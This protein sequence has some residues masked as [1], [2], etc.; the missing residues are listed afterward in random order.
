MSGHV[1]IREL[2]EIADGAPMPLHA[3]RCAECL[4]R[5]SFLRAERE[6]LRRTAARDERSV[7]PLWSGVQAR[8]ARQ[9]RSHRVVTAAL[10]AA[11][12]GGVI[13]LVARPI[14]RSPPT[15]AGPRAALDRAESEYLQ[16]ID[17]LESRIEVRERELP[18]AAL[19]ERRAARTRTRSAIAQARARELPGRMRQLEGYAAYLRSL[20][21]EL[22]E[23]P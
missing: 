7:E 11:A 12:L 1:S 3:A 21:R 17:V 18:P 14:H 22:E 20:R 4:R 2:E 8:I 23:A 16:A 13:V 5:L 19:A 9:Q 15:P 6:L 10:A